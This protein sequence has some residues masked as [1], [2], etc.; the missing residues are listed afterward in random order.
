MMGQY[1][2]AKAE[3]PDALLLFR[4]GDFYETF[5]DDAHLLA[6]ETGVILTSRNAGDP[7]P[8]PLAGFPW[9]QAE[10]YVAKLLRAGHRVEFVPI[11]V[12]FKSPHSHIRPL[13]DTCRWVRWWRRAA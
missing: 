12:V 2:R 9:H 3:H 4:M 7:E 13:R 5:F 6:R 10:S 8:I 11:H 1:L